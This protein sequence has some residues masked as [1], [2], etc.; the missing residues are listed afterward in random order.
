MEIW[1]S[2][3]SDN[4]YFDF[5]A[6]FRAFFEVHFKQAILYHFKALKVRNPTLQTM[7]KLKLK[8]R[9]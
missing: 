2:K 8:R 1:N 9:S 3:S 6:K 4:M 7:C 5:E